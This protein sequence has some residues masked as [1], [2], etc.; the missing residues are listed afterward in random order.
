MDT[1]GEN[2]PSRLDR[3]TQDGIRGISTV[4]MDSF[5]QLANTGRTPGHG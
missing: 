5:F 2:K 3:T 4:P 1:P